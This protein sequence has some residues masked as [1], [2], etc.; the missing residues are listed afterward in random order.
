[1][2]SSSSSQLVGGLGVH[3]SDWFAEG[4]AGSGRRKLSGTMFIG[5]RRPAGTHLPLRQRLRTFRLLAFDV[6]AFFRDRDPTRRCRRPCPVAAA[7]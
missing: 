2:E 7:A 4:G 3:C 5:G 1:M 6:V